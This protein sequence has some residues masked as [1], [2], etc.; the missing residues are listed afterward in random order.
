MT[1]PWKVVKENNVVGMVQFRLNDMVILCRSLHHQHHF[2]VK[3]Y[4]IGLTGCV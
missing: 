1:L 4:L 3:T 2:Q